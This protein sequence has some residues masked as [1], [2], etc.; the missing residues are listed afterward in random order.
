MAYNQFN[1]NFKFYVYKYLVAFEFC[2]S[3]K[4]TLQEQS[5]LN[6]DTAGARESVVEQAAGSI[7]N[8]RPFVQ[9]WLV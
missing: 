9:A 7:L 8:C 5:N 1:S 3:P 2:A 4:L 6:M